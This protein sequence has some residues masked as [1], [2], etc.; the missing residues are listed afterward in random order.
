MRKL[1]LKKMRFPP[2]NSIRN[3]PLKNRGCRPRG[4]GKL[5]FFGGE[6]KKKTWTPAPTPMISTTKPRHRLG[7]HQES[8]KKRDSQ[9]PKPRKKRASEWTEVQNPNPRPS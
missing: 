3:L 8:S 2:K 5:D 6:L 4:E 1:Q 9:N 7:A